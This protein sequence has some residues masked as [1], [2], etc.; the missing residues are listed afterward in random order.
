MG[1]HTHRTEDDGPCA[2]TLVTDCQNLHKWDLVAYTQ[3]RTLLYP[4]RPPGGAEGFPNCIPDASS[5]I[6][7]LQKPG[8]DD[9]KTVTGWTTTSSSFEITPNRPDASV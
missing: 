4:G 8:D 1:M 2:T 9:I 7:G 6:Q 3:R 5:S